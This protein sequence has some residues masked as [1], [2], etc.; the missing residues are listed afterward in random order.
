MHKELRLDRIRAV[1]ARLEETIIFALIERSQFK[2]NT[3]IYRPG[4]LGSALGDESLVDFLLHGTECLHSQ[5]RRY[6]S[7]DEHPFFSDLPDPILEPLNEPPV[8]ES[9]GSQSMNITI[10]EMYE[11]QVIQEIC[12]AG[13]DGQYGSSAVNDVLCLQA[14]SKRV[15]YGQ[16]VAES[17]FQAAAN[18]YRPLIQSGDR[19]GVV[20]LLTDETVE[21]NVINRVREKTSQYMRLIQDADDSSLTPEAVV[22]I[23]QDWII[24][25]NKKVQEDYL[26]KRPIT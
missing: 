4:K 16:F 3:V 23:Y 26:L 17:K 7:S 14:L 5:L 15:H 11:Q 20:D 10:R 1:L 24:P 19:Q 2:A 6:T 25:L 12:E 21:R 22:R 18:K 8:L 9:D 13:D